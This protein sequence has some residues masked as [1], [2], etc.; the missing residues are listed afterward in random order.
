MTR[1][2]APSPTSTAASLVVPM[3]DMPLVSK[4]LSNAQKVLAR[5]TWKVIQSITLPVGITALSTQE[6]QQPPRCPNSYG[7]QEGSNSSGSIFSVSHSLRFSR[8][9]RQVTHISKCQDSASFLVLGQRRSALLPHWD[10]PD[11]ALGWRPPLKEDLGGGVS[12]PH[13]KKAL[14]SSSSSS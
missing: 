13:G 1:P 4:S 11:T 14:Q 2:P 8:F 10:A 7:A 9:S 3:V 5:G 6:S 12:I